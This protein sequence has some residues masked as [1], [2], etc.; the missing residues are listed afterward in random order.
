[1]KMS[2]STIIAKFAIELT[3][4]TGFDACFNLLLETIHQLGF[5]G[6]LYMSIPVNLVPADTHKPTS[7]FQA[8]NAYPKTFL[9][10]Y[11]HENFA[12][13]DFTIKEISSGKTNLIDWWDTDRRGL[14]SQAERNVFSVAREDYQMRNGLSIPL[15]NNK[16]E[17]SGASVIS[18]DTD[19]VFSRL[20]RDNAATVSAL[21][22]LFHQRAYSDVDFQKIFIEPLLTQLS[23]KE[24]QLLKFIVTGLPI[25][26][27]DQYSDLPPGYAKN[28]IKNVCK[29]LNANN[30][31]ELRYYLG[32]YRIIDMI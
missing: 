27:I 7:I 3:Q 11:A 17:I 21:L 24:K 6:V 5:D 1:L 30:V 18:Y 20:V 13:D 16:H 26:I 31:N 14:I 9:E 28:M 29:K 25:K 8:S 19:Q 10:H 15:L 22:K 23:T 4:R 12:N 2:D 32:L